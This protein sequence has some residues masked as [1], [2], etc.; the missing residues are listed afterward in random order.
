ML[1]ITLT[2]TGDILS[3]PSWDARFHKASSVIGDGNCPLAASHD[4]RCLVTFLYGISPGDSTFLTQQTTMKLG[5]D[6]LLSLLVSVHYSHLHSLLSAQQFVPSAYEYHH[7][8]YETE[9]HPSQDPEQK[10]QLPQ[11]LLHS[12]TKNR[13]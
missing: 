8:F 1:Q 9:P 4:L 12:E 2:W 7:T 3:P 13:W 6:F 11:T 10:P 5:Y